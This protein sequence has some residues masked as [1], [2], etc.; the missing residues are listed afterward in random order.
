MSERPK[1]IRTNRVSPDVS[2][3]REIALLHLPPP[4]RDPARQFGVYFFD[5]TLERFGIATEEPDM[6]A[7]SADLRS[8]REQLESLSGEAG[9]THMEEPEYR[10]LRLAGGIAED[11][12]PIESRLVEIAGDALKAGREGA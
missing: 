4:W 12:E 7:I 2:A 11:L 3:I 10:L 1:S 6:L 5:W 9:D 8:I